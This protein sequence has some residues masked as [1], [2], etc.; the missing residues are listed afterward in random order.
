MLTEAQKLKLYEVYEVSHQADIVV[1]LG[2]GGQSLPSP[3]FGVLQGVKAQLDIAIAFINTDAAQSERVGEI[4]A[5]FDTF[6]LDPSTIDREG[7]KFNPTRNLKRIRQALFPYTGIL[8]NSSSSN[9][10]PLG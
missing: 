6:W 9:R 2:Q 5:E 10:I 7:Y 1:T 3:V 4:L 8:F